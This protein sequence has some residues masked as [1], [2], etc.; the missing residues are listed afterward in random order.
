[1]KNKDSKVKCLLLKNLHFLDLVATTTTWF[2]YSN[3]S[4]PRK[5]IFLDF[6]ITF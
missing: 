5:W 2:S 6:L 1:M 3:R 4:L